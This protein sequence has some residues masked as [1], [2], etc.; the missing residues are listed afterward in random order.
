MYGIA[1][2]DTVKKAR[3]FMTQRELAFDFIDYKKQ[4][5]PADL[6]NEWVAA[7]GWERLLNRK[8]N[9]WRGLDEAAQAAATDAAGA[10]RLMLAQPS[11]IKRPVVV[12]AD[13]RLTVGFDAAEWATRLRG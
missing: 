8:G 10:T 1:N 13:G 7:L 4:G 9:T 5:V 3:A 2:C 11:V 12:W 6:L